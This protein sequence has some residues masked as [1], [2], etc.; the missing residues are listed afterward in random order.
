MSRENSSQ[1]RESDAIAIETT[2]SSTGNRKPLRKSDAIVIETSSS[3]SGNRNVFKPLRPK[4]WRTRI[5]GY[6][7][8]GQCP[9]GAKCW[10]A[11]GQSELQPHNASSAAD[12]RLNSPP[13]ADSFRSN[14]VAPRPI[15][16]QRRFVPVI[17]SSKTSATTVTGVRSRNFFPVSAGVRPRESRYF[18]EGKKIVGIYADWLEDEDD[19]GCS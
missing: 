4:F 17:R 8:R 19:D 15:P 6:W 9:N 11:H 10:Y 18:P 14:A 12:P 13:V 5:C 3:S 1:Q 2:D 7:E 16:A